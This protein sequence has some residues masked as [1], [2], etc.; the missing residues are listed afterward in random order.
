MRGVVRL[1]CASASRTRGRT[2]PTTRS[3]GVKNGLSVTNSTRSR[4]IVEWSQQFE[5]PCIVFEYPN[6]LR[7][8]LDYGTRMSRR[9]HHLP[10]RALRYYTSYR[11]SFEG[12]PTECINPEYTSYAI[13]AVRTYGACE[14]EQDAVQLQGLFPSR[15]QRPWCKRQHCCERHQKVSRLDCARSQQPSRCS[16]GAMASIGGCGRPD[17]NPLVRPRRP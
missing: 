2:A 4:H 12:I 15:P 14:S 10:F 11:V 5:T 16:D 9:L 1:R 17:H 6:E 8:S 13:P 7:D 3:R